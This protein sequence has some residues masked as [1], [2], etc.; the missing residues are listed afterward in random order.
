ML[1]MN[2]RSPRG[3]RHPASSLKTIASMLSPTGVEVVRVSIDVGNFCF[4]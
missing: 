1:A 4:S 3:I 2:R